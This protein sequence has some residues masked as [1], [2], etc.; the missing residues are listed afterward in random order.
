[1]PLTMPQRMLLSRLSPESWAV[2]EVIEPDPYLRGWV[3]AQLKW[4]VDLD[5]AHCVSGQWRRSEAGTAALLQR[6]EVRG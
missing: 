1:M 2:L 5:L 6:E 4:L 3:A